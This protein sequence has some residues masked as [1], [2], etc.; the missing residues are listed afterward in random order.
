[1]QPDIRVDDPTLPAALAAHL[2]LWL[3][4]WPPEGPLDVVGT[5]RRARPGW[6][7]VVCPVIGVAGPGGAVLSVAGDRVAA[8]AELAATGGREAIRAGLAGAVG[9]PRHLYSERV[10][11]WCPEPAPLAEIGTWVTP[12]TPGLPSWLRSFRGQVLVVRDGSGNHLAGVGIKRHDRYGHELSAVTSRRG[13]GH[14]LARRLVA[15][16]ARRVLAEGA[17]PTY[18]HATDNIPSARVA[19]AVGFTDRGWTLCRVDA[20]PTLNARI[21]RALDRL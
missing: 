21:R 12:D 20:P 8:V 9:L 16:A 7:G 1:M 13:R 15:Q 14:G 11:R 5:D 17:V 3:G 18:I 2:A 4:R 6:D 10:F 19:A